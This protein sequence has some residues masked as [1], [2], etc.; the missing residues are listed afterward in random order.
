MGYTQNTQS[1]T[2]IQKEIIEVVFS[3]VTG[4][5][6]EDITFTGQSMLAPTL[7]IEP[8][9]TANAYGELGQQ[10]GQDVTLEFSAIGTGTVADWTAYNELKDPANICAYM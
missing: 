9:R 4:G 8:V 7:V 2:T 3:T 1:N 10:V 5:A 6:T